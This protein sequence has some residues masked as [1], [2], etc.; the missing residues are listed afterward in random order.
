MLD[1]FGRGR[2]AF[3]PSQ[4]CGGAAVLPDD[5]VVDR[6]AG[7]A[8]PDDGGLALIGDADARRC[9]RR[10]SPA[11][12]RAASRDVSSCDLP[13]FV[14]VMLDPAGL[15]KDLPEL[16]LRDGADARRRGRRRWRANWWCLDRE[17]G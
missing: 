3:R 6:L 5:G 13:D 16:L 1:Q 8:I 17:R 11:L 7:F 9:R 2:R 10:V 4:N 15:R 14:G 12:L